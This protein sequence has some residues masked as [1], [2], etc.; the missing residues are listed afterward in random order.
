M[1]FNNAYKFMNECKTSGTLSINTF[2]SIIITSGG[3]ILSI[4]LVGQTQD[5]CIIIV[6]QS[7]A[8]VEV[9]PLWE[10]ELGLGCVPKGTLFPLYCTTFDPSP[11][12]PGQK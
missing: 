11:M 1:T 10:W 4:L 12:E 2:Y 5:N 7:V 8:V 9:P 3:L 6:S